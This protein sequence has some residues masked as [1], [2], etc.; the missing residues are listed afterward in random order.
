[1]TWLAAIKFELFFALNW[2]FG[3][4]L[5]HLLQGALGKKVKIER[6]EDTYSELKEMALDIHLVSRNYNNEVIG[7]EYYA[8]FDVLTEPELIELTTLWQQKLAKCTKEKFA[9][10]WL[11]VQ[12]LFFACFSTYLAWL[13]HHYAGIIAGVVAIISIMKI[14]EQQRIRKAKKNLADARL[15]YEKLERYLEKIPRRNNRYTH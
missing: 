14:T 1:L 7:I 12:V 9:S 8:N 2:F 3:F 6:D 10:I 11:I 13:S 15:V 4:I 5:V